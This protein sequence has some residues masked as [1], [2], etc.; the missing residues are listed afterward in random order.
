MK[1]VQFAKRWRNQVNDTTVHEYPA[2]WSGEVSN[3]A[4]DRAVAAKVLKGAPVDVPDDKP[5][6][7]DGKAKA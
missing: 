6:K 3:E 4:A 1:M 7:T 5:A 2:G